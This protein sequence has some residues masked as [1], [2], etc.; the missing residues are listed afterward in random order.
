MLTRSF[1]HISMVWSL[2][3]VDL[4]GESQQSTSIILLRLR[5]CSV[6]Y[7]DMELN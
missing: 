2:T 3:N 4:Y 6:R 5:R 1:I 7:P